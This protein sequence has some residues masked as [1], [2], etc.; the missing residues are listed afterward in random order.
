MQASGVSITCVN[1]A[2]GGSAGLPKH[3]IELWLL[4]YSASW[5]S[6]T[7]RI[8]TT[9]DYSSRIMH[10]RSSNCPEFISGEFWRFLMNG[11]AT[12]FIWHELKQIFMGL[13]GNSYLNGGSC[14]YKYL[15]AVNS[16]PNG[17][18]QNLFRGLPTT[19]R[20]GAAALYQTRVASTW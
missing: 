15:G 2:W 14:T 3:F 1:I 10:S 16:Y 5:P 6:W 8:P 4:H 9:T 13:S 20:I 19:C 11:V 17:I 7:P 12:N 18:A